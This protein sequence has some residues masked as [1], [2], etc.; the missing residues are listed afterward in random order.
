MD[1]YSDVAL[2]VIGSKWYGSNKI[3]DFTESVELMSKSLSGPIVFT[4]FLTPA[5]VPQY[6]DIGDIFVCPSQ[7]EEPLARVHYEAMAAGLPIIT[8]NRGGN[9]EVI[10]GV[11]N[12]IIIDDYTNPNQ[13]ASKIIELLENPKGASEMGK[14]GRAI[15]EEKYNWNRVADD[16]LSLFVAAQNSILPETE[17]F[18]VV[19]IPKTEIKPS[20]IITEQEQVKNKI[21]LPTKTRKIKPC[22]KAPILPETIIVKEEKEI[23]A[24]IKVKKVKEKCIT[25]LNAYYLEIYKDNID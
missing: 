1:K 5:E 10:K 14:I 9:A 2:V 19:E 17:D 20:K 21:E 12:G 7:W 18:K 11:G 6:Y 16:I 24:E 13:F 23:I 3:D 25:S 8:T 4:G 22:I 15:A